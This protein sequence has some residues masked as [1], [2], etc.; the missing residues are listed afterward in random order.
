MQT[1]QTTPALNAPVSSP[2][3]G[4][5]GRRSSYPRERPQ[6]DS[7]RLA[8]SIEMLAEEADL[9]GAKTWHAIPEYR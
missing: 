3:P 5:A 2:A 6:G 9:A 4:L 7:A 1:P 8:A